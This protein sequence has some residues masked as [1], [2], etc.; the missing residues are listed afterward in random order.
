LHVEDLA[1][2]FFCRLRSLRGQRFDLGR[3][4]RKAAA[5]VAGSRRFNSCIEC[6]KIHPF[7]N[8][9]DK[10]SFP[11][12]AEVLETGAGVLLIGGLALL[13]SALPVIL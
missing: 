11:A 7:R 1:A 6:K 4:D 2:D 9:T 12:K 10:A 5:C 3:D 8:G 13:G